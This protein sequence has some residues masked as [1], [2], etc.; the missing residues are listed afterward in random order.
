MAT[1]ANPYASQDLYIAS[2]HHERLRDFVS[3]SPQDHRPFQRQVDAWWAALAIGARQKVKTP[4]PQDAVKFN[5]GRILAAD[6]W[7]IIHL[8]LL[9]LAAEGPEILDS[10]AEVIRMASEFAN[11]G[12]P[13]LLDRLVGQ[14]EPTL[15]LMVRL[16]ELRQ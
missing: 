6:P 13:E 11:T 3:R 9:A 14:V 16:E 10:P 15:N 5:D 2:P 12:F 7:R 1:I 8:E 4:L